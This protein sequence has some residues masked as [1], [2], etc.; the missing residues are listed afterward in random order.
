MW[1]VS[2]D[3]VWDTARDLC[4]YVKS[5]V[6]VDWVVVFVS[7]GGAWGGNSGGLPRFIFVLSDVASCTFGVGGRG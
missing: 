3:V 4:M 5:L 7:K 2:G 1:G 6:V